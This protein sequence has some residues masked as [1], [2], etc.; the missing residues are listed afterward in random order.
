V[1]D[2]ISN[3]IPIVNVTSLTDS[4]TYNLK[5]AGSIMKQVYIAEGLAPPK[6]LNILQDA[7]KTMYSRAIDA[8]YWSKMVNNGEWKK[9]ALYAVEVYG[10]FNIGEMVSLLKEGMG[11]R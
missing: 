10:I 8:N 11:R 4:L 5:V 3:T 2:I 1:V 7:Y 9:F 6:S